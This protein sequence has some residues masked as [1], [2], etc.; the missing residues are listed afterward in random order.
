MLLMGYIGPTRKDIVLNVELTQ[1]NLQ[2]AIEVAL[3]EEL[4][5]GWSVDLVDWV[6]G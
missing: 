3:G 6:E 1:E 4:E 5:S 2:A